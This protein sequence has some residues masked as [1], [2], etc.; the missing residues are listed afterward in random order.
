MYKKID[1]NDIAYL[2]TIFA[3]SMIL[4]GDEIEVITPENI[5]NLKVLEIKSE[6]TVH[7]AIFEK[8]SSYYG[9]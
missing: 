9:R 5:Y 2:K 8:H 4:V 1:N 3:P 7:N 6:N